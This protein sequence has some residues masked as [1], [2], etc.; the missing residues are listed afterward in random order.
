MTLKERLDANQITN[1]EF[2]VLSQHEADKAA[3]DEAQAWLEKVK[4]APLQVK[5][6]MVKEQSANM[7]IEASLMDDGY[8]AKAKNKK[9]WG[10]R[11]ALRGAGGISF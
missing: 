9:A 3:T 10:L 5:K 7:Q 6:Q 2:D 1:E 11:K 4:A 8:E